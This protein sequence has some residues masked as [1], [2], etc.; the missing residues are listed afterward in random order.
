M[1][2]IRLFTDILEVRAGMELYALPLDQLWS[3]VV[4]T[5]AVY[6]IIAP[7]SLNDSKLEIWATQKKKDGTFLIGRI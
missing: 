7:T 6:E 2:I 5:N 3:H 1:L 4:C